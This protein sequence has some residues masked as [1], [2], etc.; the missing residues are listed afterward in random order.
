MVWNFGGIRW[1]PV[2][3]IYE[4]TLTDDEDPDAAKMFVLYEP[5]TYDEV[6]NEDDHDK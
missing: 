3:L 4:H 5:T 2:K 1:P 6:M